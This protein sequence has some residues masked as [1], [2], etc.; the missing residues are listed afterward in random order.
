[1]ILRK[2]AVEL[3]MAEAT[4]LSYQGKEE[5]LCRA[6][7]SLKNSKGRRGGHAGRS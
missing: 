1:M 6:A 2:Y 3:H 5:V 4:I 7:F